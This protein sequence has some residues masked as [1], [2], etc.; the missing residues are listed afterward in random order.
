MIQS[1][2]FIWLKGMINSR[3][4]LKTI[5]LGLL[6]LSYAQADHT[7]GI[8]GGFVDIQDVV[9]YVLVEM[10]YATPHNF[11]GSVIEGY[12]I[13]RCLITREAAVALAEV[14]K[15]LLGMGLCLKIYDAYRPQRAVDHFVR[16]AKHLSDT[17][18]KREFFPTVHKNRLFRE[19]YIASRSG[20][21]RGSTL[22][23][24]I[25]ALPLYEPSPYAPGD[26]LCE[27]Y[28]PATRRFPDNSL[29]MGTGYDCF[30]ELSHTANPEIG[31][32]QR[33]NRLLLKTLM[34]MHGFRNYKKEWWHFTLVDEPYPDTYFDFP[35][36]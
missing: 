30:H 5:F 8:P 14:Q 26:T 35:I 36:Q 25:V 19:G 12:E 20:H 29:D 31:G 22:D 2:P 11:V 7:A 4:I 1:F 34:E 32:Q 23:L 28:L 21:S 27:C 15:I 10:R 6:L 13:E 24:T 33:A 18:M 16:W 17:T 9:P 3:Q